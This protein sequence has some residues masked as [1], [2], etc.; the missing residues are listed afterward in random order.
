MTS[1][2]VGLDVIPLPLVGSMDDSSNGSLH[3]CNDVMDT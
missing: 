1:F 3:G 2:R